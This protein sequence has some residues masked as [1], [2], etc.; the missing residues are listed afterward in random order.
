VGAVVHLQ[1]HRDR[2][3]VLVFKVGVASEA[4]ST[5]VGG[6]LVFGVA[7]SELV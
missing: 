1:V 7:S 3:E 4:G 5:C 6:E 2:E